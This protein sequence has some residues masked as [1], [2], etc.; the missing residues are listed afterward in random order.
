MRNLRSWASSITAYIY[1]F[2]SHYSSRDREIKFLNF[3]P[4]VDV[5]VC[6]TP[7]SSLS[8]CVRS[9]FKF[10]FKVKI[11]FFYP[12]LLSETWSANSKYLIFLEVESPLSTCFHLTKIGTV[13]PLSAVLGRT[14]F[15][16]QKPRITE[17]Q[18]IEVWLY[19]I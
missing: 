14:K 4:N 7:L 13:I 9:F 12:T 17:A 11:V 5:H 18:I 8:A 1:T 10:E 15:W 19:F 2:W 6:L 16:S 3:E